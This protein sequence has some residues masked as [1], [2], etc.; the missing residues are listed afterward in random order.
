MMHLVERQWP[1][2]NFDRHRIFGPEGGLLPVGRVT[3][4]RAM[5]DRSTPVIGIV[6]AG[7]C[8][9][10]PVRRERARDVDGADDA[11]GDGRANESTVALARAVDIV[12]ILPLSLDEA[13]VLRSLYG[14]A[15]AAQAFCPDRCIVSLVLA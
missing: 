7:Q 9:D 8:R 13:R 3:L 5:Q 10:D 4:N 14:L 12:G 2:R 11:M 6:A 15:D 1:L